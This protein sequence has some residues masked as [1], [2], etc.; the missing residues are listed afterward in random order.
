VASS[1]P[2]PTACGGTL[3]GTWA[4]GSLCLPQSALF[5]RVTD[6]C[7]LATIYG[8][9]ADSASGTLSVAAG[10][11]TL[12]VS[13]KAT[14]M[15]DFPNACTGCRCTDLETELGSV[16]LIASCSPVCNGGVCTCT[17]EAFPEV[18]DSGHY[19]S[20]ATTFTT[21]G[22]DTFDYC[23]SAGGITTA[24]PNGTLGVASFVP[25]TPIP[26]KCDGIDNDGNGIIDDNPRDCPPACLSQGVCATYT[27]ACDGAAGWVCSY[28]STY[29]QTE[30]LCDGLDNDCNGTVDDEPAADAQCAAAKGAGFVCAGGACTCPKQVCGG[31]CVDTQTDVANCGTCGHACPT[32]ATCV[33]GQCQCPASKPSTCGSACVDT[34][35]DAA[36]CSTCGHACSVACSASKCLGVTELALGQYTSFAV[37]S[38]GSARGW[39]LDS[40]GDLGNGT[41]FQGATP[42]PSQV[43]GLSTTAHVASGGRCAWL[44]SGAPYCWGAN[45]FGQL[46]DGT[47]TMRT[48]PTAI[49]GL[50]TVAGVAASDQF[51]CAWVSG[52]SAYCWG[53]GSNFQLGT[54]NGSQQLTP[55]P[56]T[57]LSS[58]AEVA[59]GLTH[60]C[61]RTSAGAVYCWGDNLEGECGSAFSSVVQ[62]PTQVMGI[63]ATQIVS[64]DLHSCALGSGG[65]V[66]CWGY[67]NYGQLGDGMSAPEA[68]PVPVTGL[69]SVVQIAAGSSHTCARLADGTVQ[70]WGWNQD[71]E[72]GDGTNMSR[73]SPVAVTG[74]SGAVQIVAGGEHTCALV[75]SGAVLCWGN[76]TFGEV[77][78]NAP[79]TASTPV[80]VTW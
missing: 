68:S 52:G 35:T 76:N 30:S 16:G 57:G 26:E 12:D 58:V 69:S 44:A 8:V 45:D 49:S 6:V 73:S 27:E 71:G 20:T 5:A 4:L 62:T 75:G 2:A 46:G 29:Q 36:N 19:T 40:Q 66:Q 42:I 64:G 70:C 34:T 3:R 22:N 60:A 55:A 72:I 10:T 11:L 50:A 67:D 65:T 38:D 15:V 1:C 37:L 56:V 47:Q 39:G 80:A 7:S 41:T 14:A 31:A 48:S 61:A 18:S 43:A 28:P 74:V 9:T 17:V 24:D 59:A 53:D 63:T 23:A 78:A 13:A 79:V 77:G 51:T 25:P 33:A 54:G 21:A 32:L